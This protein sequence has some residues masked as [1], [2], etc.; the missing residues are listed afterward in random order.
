MIKAVIR[1]EGGQSYG[2]FGF[3]VLPRPSDRVYVTNRA[4]GADALDVLYVEHLPVPVPSTRLGNT[5]PVVTVVVA[6]NRGSEGEHKHPT[7]GP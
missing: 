1:H 3:A 2:M 4:G 7:C 6:S 5:D